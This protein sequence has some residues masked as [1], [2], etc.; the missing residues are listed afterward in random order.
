MVATVMA[1]WPAFAQTADGAA[2]DPIQ[3]YKVNKPVSEFPA[4][5]DLSTPEAACAAWQRA[6]AQKDAQAISQLSWAKIDPQQKEQSY[7]NQEKKDPE[8]LALYLK[9]L[10]DSKILAVQVW[11][12]E[13]ANVVTLLPFPPGKGRDPYSA[14]TFGRINGEW[15]NLGEDRL[16][17]LEAAVAGFDKKKE[18]LWS[19]FESL[20]RQ[21]AP[22]RAGSK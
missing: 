10:A 22:A 16:P 19:N 2:T 20:R 5:K 9:A 21:N 15:K 12:G 14:R 4:G 1:A 8:G 3:S 18:V 17:S 6:S 13:L 11:R 7:R